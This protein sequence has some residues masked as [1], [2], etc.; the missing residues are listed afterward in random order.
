MS[1]GRWR[2]PSPTAPHWASQLLSSWASLRATS[3]PELWIV[4]VLKLLESYAY[5]SLSIIFTI[6]LTE[7][8]GFSDEEAGVAYG[9]WGA[10]TSGYGLLMGFVVD[11]LGVRKSLI[12]GFGVLT[13]ARF[14]LGV[15][16]SGVALKVCV[17]FLLPVGQSMGIP[18]L[19]TG[20][21]R[22]T[23]ERDRGFAFGVF[24]SFMNVAALLS[25]WVVDWLNLVL[26]GRA[27]KTMLPTTDDA[28]TSSRTGPP[29]A[30]TLEQ[31][32]F[33][34]NRIVVLTG[35]AASG[36]GLLL[37]LFLVR[38]IRVNEASSDGADYPGPDD[39]VDK[40]SSSEDTRSNHCV[41]DS[42]SSSQPVV[43]VFVPSRASPLKIAREL[44]STP[45]FWRY[46]GFVVLITNLNMIFRH[47]DATLPKYLVRQFGANVPKGT[48][49]S[50]RDED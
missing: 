50:I 13:V 34:A 8:F 10:L 7:E 37:A 49:Y 15:T 30:G 22:Y 12:F 18:V 32:A 40:V 3:A 43:N 16:R 6:F 2:Q 28:G 45:T 24:Y 29:T 27:P 38:E 44:A 46:L 11:N 4:Y 25:G 26:G 20:I 39:V 41:K 23:V 17:F 5:F 1:G 42:G 35:A 14:L 19:A 47:L 36:L 21:R 31:G 9:L 33:S 48:L